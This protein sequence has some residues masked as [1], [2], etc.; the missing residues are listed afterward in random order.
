MQPV[1]GTIKPTTSKL[2]LKH[3]LM[4][5]I[6]S[7]RNVVLQHAAAIISRAARLGQRG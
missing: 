6:S 7:S 5:V 4:V 1:F 3:F 2:K